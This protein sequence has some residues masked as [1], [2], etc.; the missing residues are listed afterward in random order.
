MN[1]R[2][3]DKA[4][5]AVSPEA[6]N[7]RLVAVNEELVLSLIEAQKRAETSARLLEEMSLSIGPDAVTHLP[8][9]ALLL[10]RLVQAMASARLHQS[11]L[12]LLAVDVGHFA[13]FVARRGK[14]AGDAAL[15]LLAGHMGEAV[16]KVETISRHGAHGF[17]VLLPEAML[18]EARAV[19]QRVIEATDSTIGPDDDMPQLT[20]SV[21]GALFPDHGQSPLDLISSAEAAVYW[22]GQN[23]ERGLVIFDR[24]M[25]QPPQPEPDESAAFPRPSDEAFFRTTE[26]PLQACLR[27]ANEQLLLASMMSMDKK[28]LAEKAL[29]RQTD[30][31]AVLAHELRTPLTPISLAAAMMSEV[32]A[33]EIPRLQNVIS[34]QIVHISRLLTDLLDVSR[35]N[36]GKVRLKREAVSITS[37]L[38]QSI[39]TCAPAIAL[40]AQVLTTTLPE[41]PIRVLGDPVR[42]AQVFTNLLDNA[43]K[44]TPER[45][46]IDV[47]VSVDEAS[48]IVTVKDSGIGVSAEALPHIFEPFVQDS[49]AVAFN[50]GGLGIGLTVVRD[51]IEAHG[52]RVEVHSNGE[53]AGTSFTVTLGRLGD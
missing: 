41:N 32:E 2:Q 19:A 30:F 48:V 14:H 18:H 38:N 51:M 35:I 39:D 6:L 33:S 52:G 20:V 47:L 31:L 7:E 13:E 27:H 45:G 53:N 9:R 4:R 42:L 34:R 5:P 10:D 29:R 22:A 40:R 1:A 50:G 26:S 43:S 28:E 23:K 44:Y 25:R 3:G 36:T 24:S 21:G 11:P 49:T 8:N 16:G 15:R 46:A 12:A 17:L 37:V